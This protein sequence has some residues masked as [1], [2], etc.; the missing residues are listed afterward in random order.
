MSTSDLFACGVKMVWSASNP[1]LPHIIFLEFE[2]FKSL[3][4]THIFYYRAHHAD[5]DLLNDKAINRPD[6]VLRMI[7]LVLFSIAE[8]NIDHRRQQALSLGLL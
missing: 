1:V 6:Q 7:E 5:R 2:V 8:S 3:Q 4:L